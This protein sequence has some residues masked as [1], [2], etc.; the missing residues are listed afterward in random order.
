MIVGLSS[1]SLG[2]AMHQGKMDILSAMDWTKE[3]GGEFIEIVPHLFTVNGDD[4]LI[5]KT[6]VN[7][8]KL[9]CQYFSTVYPEMCLKILK[10]SMQRRLTG[11]R[12]R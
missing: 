6:T 2:K 10:R 7:L 4:E 5:S 11:L 3:N 8:Q 9:V 12:R 1:Y